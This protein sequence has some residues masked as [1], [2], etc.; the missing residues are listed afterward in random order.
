MRI[1]EKWEGKMPGVTAP[2]DDWRRR[3]RRAEAEASLARTQ[4]VAA[5]LHADAKSAHLAQ[6]VDEMTGSISWR[7]TAPLRRLNAARRA[8]RAR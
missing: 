7:M 2:P 8:R 5:M 1:A 4:A 3:A 6:Q